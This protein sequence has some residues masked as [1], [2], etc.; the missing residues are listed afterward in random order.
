[1]M[2]K[3]FQPGV[4]KKMKQALHEIIDNI[5]LLPENLSVSSS[6]N[7]PGSKIT[8]LDLI[9]IWSRSHLEIKFHGGKFL[10]TLKKHGVTEGLFGDHSLFVEG[11]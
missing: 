7:R 9:G 11:K 8:K 2:H 4:E 5:E 3:Y 10:E 1:M 6:V